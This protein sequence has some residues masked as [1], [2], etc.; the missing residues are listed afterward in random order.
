MEIILKET[1]DTLGQEGE[2]VKVKPGYAR[3]YLI[4]QKKAVLVTDENL[5]SLEAEKQAIADRLEAERKETEKM[6][7][8]L[9]GKV[10]VIQKRVGD[11]NRLFGSVTTAEIAEALE[12][13]GVQIDKK[14]ILLKTAIK[15]IGEYT[16]SVKVGYQTT[17]DIKVQVVPEQLEKAAS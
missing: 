8:K 2:I 14:V 17:A 3:N 13:E 12:K 4:P 6:S 11:E 15:A 1:I 16:I 5:A 10:L 7:A 9:A